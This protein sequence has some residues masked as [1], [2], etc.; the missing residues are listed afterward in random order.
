MAKTNNVHQVAYVVNDLNAA[1]EQWMRVANIGPFFVQRD[2]EPQNLIYRGQPTEGF[3]ADIA[4]CQMGPV[5][6]ELIQ[7]RSSG[8]NVY[9][10]SVPKGT[11]GFHHYAYFTE[12]MDAEFAR[13]AAMGV[14]VGA[15]ATFGDVRFAYFDTRDE[16][17]CMTETITHAADLDAIFKMV[18]DA[19][20]DW[21]GSNPVRYIE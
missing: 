17:G 19:A 3:L 20:V 5:Q 9:H 7:V 21:D 13:F 2:C 10:D 4:Y 18:A 8:P 14:E 1:I 15:Q 16:V 12:D 11:D 6:L